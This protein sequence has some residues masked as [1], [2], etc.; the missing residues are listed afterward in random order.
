MVTLIVAKWVG[1]YFNHGIYD[2]ILHVKKVEEND[3]L[4]NSPREKKI[5]IFNT[6]HLLATVKPRCRCWN[7]MVRK[8]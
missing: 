3:E 8:K 4:T 5:I 1:D 7:G 2:T 6:L